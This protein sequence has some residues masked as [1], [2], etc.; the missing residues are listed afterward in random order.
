MSTTDSI[1]S[2]T[3]L[4]RLTSTIDV[5]QHRG[6]R[7]ADVEIEWFVHDRAT[8]PDYSALLDR[9]LP[10]GPYSYEQ[11][12]VDDLF[13]REEADQFAAYL[14]SRHGDSVVLQEVPVPVAT[15]SP[16]GVGLIGISAVPVGGCTDFHMLSDEDGYD[17]PFKVWGW[18]TV[19]D[20][21]L[22]ETRVCSHECSHHPRVDEW[23]TVAD[24]WSGTG[25]VGTFG[26]ALTRAG[27]ILGIPLADRLTARDS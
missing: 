5:W 13:T 16:H 8:V 15:R 25:P 2:A 14:K 4:Y 9:P 23:K 11:G 3:H 21:K 7:Y 19:E 12:L 18:Y 10:E 6:G 17:L 1:K 26:D 27:D 20:A 24:P 22:V